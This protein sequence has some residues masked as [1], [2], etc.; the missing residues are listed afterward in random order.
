MKISTVLIATQFFFAFNCSGQS[1]YNSIDNFETSFTR[2]KRDMKI[3]CQFEVTFNKRDNGKPFFITKDST[4][5]E[6]DFFD[7]T[8]TPF[9]DSTQTNA[10]TTSAY[11][12]W[13]LQKKGSLKT[14]QIDKID[15]S[16]DKGYFVLKIHDASGEFYKL[17]GRSDNILFSIKLSDNQ[18]PKQ[19]LLEKLD[20]LYLLNKN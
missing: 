20:I 6:F 2:I 8:S 3:P 5:I 11:Y 13:I 17:A 18:L 19:N 10:E 12:D 9:Y 15:E 16:T 14:I 7:V 4:Q 1:Q